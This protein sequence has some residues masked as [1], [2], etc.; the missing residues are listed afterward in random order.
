M[1]PDGLNRVSL[2]AFLC[3]SAQTYIQPHT[4]QGRFRLDVRMYYFSR[5]VIRRWNGLLR[6]LVE[7]PTLE[8]FKER[9]DAVLRD[10]V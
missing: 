7:S 1:D 3:L 8:V 2:S 4:H 5:R 10:M 6:E 9:L